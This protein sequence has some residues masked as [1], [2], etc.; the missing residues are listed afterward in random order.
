LY[1]CALLSYRRTQESDTQSF[2][3]FDPELWHRTRSTGKGGAA[4]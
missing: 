4:R 3:P 2:G 1:A